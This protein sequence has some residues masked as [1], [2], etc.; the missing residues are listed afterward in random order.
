MAWVGLDWPDLP[1]DFPEPRPHPAPPR[2]PVP[3]DI[4]EQVRRAE[5]RRGV[6]VPLCVLAGVLLFCAGL[7][8]YHFAGDYR[9]P[10]QPPTVPLTLIV[11]GLLVAPL[12]PALSVLLG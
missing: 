11:A 2:P 3:A 8:T 1:P 9:H 7:P 10:V 5:R 12:V 6:I 4:A